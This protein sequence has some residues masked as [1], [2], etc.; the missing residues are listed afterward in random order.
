M[1]IVAV[2]PSTNDVTV[3][4]DDFNRYRQHY[5]FEVEPRVAD[6]DLSTTHLVL[7]SIKYNEF[8]K[9]YINKYMYIPCSRNAT[10][11]SAL[12][13]DRPVE[14]Q[15]NI[16]VIAS[17]GSMIYLVVGVQAPSNA[18]EAPQPQREYHIVIRW[19]CDG[20]I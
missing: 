7:H 13:N 12:E 17:R 4:S 9:W 16:L 3:R 11:I 5:F 10:T 6:S 15:S 2:F 19:G 1:Q 8:S 14:H 18:N 20:I